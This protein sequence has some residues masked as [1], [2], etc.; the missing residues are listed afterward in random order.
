MWLISSGTY[1]SIWGGPKI[2]GTPLGV[3]MMRIILYWSLKLGYPYFGKLQ[4][5]TTQPMGLQVLQPG[6][7]GPSRTRRSVAEGPAFQH[8]VLGFEFTDITAVHLNG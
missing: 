2:R 8:T 7:H 3:P 4:F 5:V 6:R 1:N